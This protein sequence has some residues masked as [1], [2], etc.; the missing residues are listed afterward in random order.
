MA[1]IHR[2][3]VTLPAA[4][5]ELAFV[6]PDS[7]LLDVGCGIGKVAAGFL[8]YL[9]SRGRYYG[10]DI[11]K[12]AIAWVTKAYL[13]H[14]NFIF[15]H[16]DIK[17]L[18]YNPGGVL[19]AETY[20]FPYPSDH[21][22]VVYLGS[23]FTHDMPPVV[24]HFLREIHRVLKPGGKAVITWFLLNDVNRP[25]I[26]AGKANVPLLHE[27]PYDP[28]ASVYRVAD[29]ND[30]EAAVGYEESVVLK[31]YRD[32]GFLQ[33]EVFYGI[34]SGRPDRPYGRRGWDGQGGYQD[35]ILSVKSA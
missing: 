29:V 18:M 2:F 4:L 21:F 20:Q 32:V 28:E 34:W 26:L 14:P 16:A 35:M 30:P 33:Q 5:I 3:S 1:C 22:D 13:P 6:Q 12:P 7:A 8:H 19:S 9:D 25:L 15:H 11:G 23:V 27:M 31:Y 17:S 10:F 24:R